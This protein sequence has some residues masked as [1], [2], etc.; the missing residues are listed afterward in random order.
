M[1]R[2]TTTALVALAAMIAVPAAGHAQGGMMGMMGGGCPT[3]GMMGNGPGAGFGWG[4]GGGWGNGGW[5]GGMMGRQPRMGAMVEGR[6]AYL[7]GELGITPAQ[8]AAWDTYE[9]AVKQRVEL[10]QDLHEGMTQTIQEGN[11]TERMDARITGMEAMVESMKAMKPATEALYA[12]LTD[13]QKA[14]ADD[15]IG[16][17][18]GAF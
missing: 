2:L 3:I 7:K 5:G 6:L 16:G 9:K 13:E 8:Q 12:V 14:I 4:M 18:C 11:A 17:D 1:Y 10:M 15:L